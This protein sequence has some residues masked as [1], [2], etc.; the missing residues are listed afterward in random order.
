ME[1]GALRCCGTLVHP[2]SFP[3]SYG[4]GDLGP[5]AR[6][7]IDFLVRN[8]Q[9]VWQLLPLGPT[10]YGNSPYASWSAFAGNP[11]LISPDELVR[12]GLLTDTE[13]EKNHL[14]NTGRVAYEK[15]RGEKE[16]LLRLAGKRFFD[17]SDKTE[18]Q[19]LA[20]FSDHNK[21]WLEDFVLFAVCRRHFN[22]R[23][24][25]TWD[26]GIRSRNRKTVHAWIEEYREELWYQRWLQFE[27]DNQW[28]SI[29]RYANERGIIVIGDLP[30]Y[31]DHNSADVWA[32]PGLFEIDGEGNRIRVSGV[33]PDY[34]S[35]TGQLWGNPLY[36][37][38][39][40][41]RQKF[42][43][44]LDRF[45]RQFNLFDYVRVDHFR[46][47]ESYWAVSAGAK[48]A[49]NG[50]WEKAPGQSLFDRLNKYFGKL[51]VIAEDLGVMTEA[52]MALRDRYGFPGM[53]VLQFAFTG[54][55][56]HPFLPHNYGHDNWA[57]YTGTHDNDTTI[58]WY[59]KAT[60]KER[61]QARVYTRSNGHEINWELIRTAMFSVASMAVFPLQDLMSLGSDSRM[62]TPGT[63]SGNWEWRFTE[64]MLRETDIERFR[65]L[66][67]QSNRLNPFG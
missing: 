26:S 51:P 36:N 6:H 34:F 61:H 17:R 20:V 58:G 30:I 56:D 2:T 63:I 39:V 60:E 4:I 65:N 55:P 40:L 44:W 25:N 59:E 41:K 29:R 1:K 23:S 7:F 64:S 11:Y 67:E 22:S 10:G 49:E 28:R 12:K 18:M 50:Q 14:A 27:F 21:N 47:F 38:K 8:G 52:V 57:V 16:K 53:K 43:W 66:A 42:S 35:K 15:A 45:K 62:N 33:P 5:D 9:S 48:T 19:R 54:G 3:G 13:A 24:W 37:W 46:G 31:V 32:H